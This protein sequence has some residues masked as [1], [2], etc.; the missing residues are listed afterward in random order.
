MKIAS[1]IF[2]LVLVGLLGFVLYQS[3]ALV[4]SVRATREEPPAPVVAE[5]GPAAPVEAPPSLPLTQPLAAPRDVHAELYEK[6]VAAVEALEQGELARAIELLERCLAEKPDEPAFAHNLAE[7]LVR[8]AQQEVLAEDAEVREAAIGHLRRAIALAPGRAELPGLLE[9]WEKSLASEAGFWRKKTVHFELSFDGDRSELLAGTG[10]LESELE[11]AYH[12]IGELFGYFPVEAGR[13]RL[14]VVLLA[15][16]QF[17][18]V[19]G[20][21]DWAGGVFDGT[22]RVPVEDLASEQQQV[23]RALR[24]ELVHAFVHETG[25]SS[26]PGWLNEGLAQWLEAP[27][28]VD[29]PHDVEKAR[30]RL[31]GV[32]PFPLERLR[33]TL[34]SWK[35]VGEIEIAYA[36]SLAFVDH[37]RRTYGERL[38]FDLVAGCKEGRTPE[39]TFAGARGRAREIAHEDVA[40]AR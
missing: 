34:A 3:S 40:A 38:L 13:P 9:R 6:N 33:G 1:T 24:H 37:L 16:A 25:G 14:R 4:D 15:R 12:E 17:G 39:E 22:V 31:D 35:D 32:Q 21:G 30:G 8:T 26:V 28:W 29:R 2:L 19:T 20:L 23:K 11:S 36:Q 27:F 10:P 7:A 5:P 18:S